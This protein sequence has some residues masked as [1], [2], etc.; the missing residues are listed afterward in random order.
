M[1]LLTSPQCTV[2]S[3]V[4]RVIQSNSTHIALALRVSPLR[5]GLSTERSCGVDLACSH[6]MCTGKWRLPRMYAG[7]RFEVRRAGVPGCRAAADWAFKRGGA[8]V[9]V[10]QPPAGRHTGPHLPR[11][12]VAFLLELLA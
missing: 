2:H 9:P 10:Q 4:R 5:K 1:A 11:V 7:T 12:K 6:L 3:T 8:A